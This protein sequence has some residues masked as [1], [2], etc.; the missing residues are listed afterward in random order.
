MIYIS[1]C[2]NKS[3]LFV[4]F[5]IKNALQGNR[6]HFLITH[7]STLLLVMSGEH[8]SEINCGLLTM[9]YTIVCKIMK[10]I[11]T[12]VAKMKMSKN[13]QTSASLPQYLCCNTVYASHFFAG[14]PYHFNQTLRTA[15]KF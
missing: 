9:V 3:C 4:L 6:I 2:S 13:R 15:N 5:C 11:I 1:M 12:V 10:Y 7:H 14:R 8:G